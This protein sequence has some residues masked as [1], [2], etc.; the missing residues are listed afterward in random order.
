MERGRVL[1]I[2]ECE[3]LHRRGIRPI[4]DEEG[5]LIGFENEKIMKEETSGGTGST[6]GRTR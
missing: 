5:R 4:T 6:K 2:E 3:S 1:S